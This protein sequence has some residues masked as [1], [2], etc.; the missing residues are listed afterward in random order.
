MN[1][2][3]L[4]AASLIASMFVQ[5]QEAAATDDVKVVKNKKG[6]EVLP[7]AGDIAL[8]FDA[9][10]FLNLAINTIKVNSGAVFNNAQNTNQFVQGSSNTI[11][12]KYFLTAN[13]AIRVRIG[14]NTLS[15]SITN[16]VQ[17][18]KAVYDASFGN[19][20]EQAVAANLTVEDKYTFNKQQILVTAGYEMRRGYRRL[21]GYY[22]GEISF[23]GSGNKEYFTYGNDFTDL[24]TIQYT[25]ADIAGSNF[26][27][28]QNFNPVNSV[29][30]QERALYNNYRGGF[31]FGLR[32]FVGVEY[33]VFA[34]ISVGGEFGWGWAY[35]ARTN[36]V[37]TV[38][39]Y[40]N[41]GPLAQVFNEERS[42]DSNEK[43]K[44]FSVDNNSATT[45]PFGIGNNTTGGSG[46]NAGQNFL[47][48][49]TGAITVMFHF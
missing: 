6:Q 36:K 17:D 48:G 3:V 43:T 23:G 11:V 14:I 40:D 32:G 9:A 31:R 10:P 38:E 27:N 24:Y 7:K 33:F 4:I 34:K 45:N 47:S 22:G 18:S 5:A 39:V 2:K 20:E 19:R 26:T 25:R 16:R 21:Q 12:G 49:G 28:V 13:S 37:S 46:N 29:G 30:R 42:N 35:A 8:G 1:K 44:G 41:N 15:G